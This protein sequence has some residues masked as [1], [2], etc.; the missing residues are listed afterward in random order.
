MEA[1]SALGGVVL[2]AVISMFFTAIF[3]NPLERSI[4]RSWRRFSNSPVALRVSAGRFTNSAIQQL[5]DLDTGKYGVFTLL[6]WSPNRPLIRDPR[7]HRVEYGG[8]PDQ[9]WA[10]TGRLETEQ[11]VQA[12][13][14]RGRTGYAWAVTVDHGE[15]ED[16]DA[17]IVSAAESRYGDLNAIARAMPGVDLVDYVTGRIRDEGI[18]LLRTM[19]PTRLSIQV[20]VVAGSGRVMALRRSAAVQSVPVQWQLGPN[21]TLYPADAPDTPGAIGES[22]FDLAHRC[23]VEE[24]GLYESEVSP[25]RISWFGLAANPDEGVAQN[26]LACTT[27]A[28]SEAQI[29]ERTLNAHSNYESDGFDWIPADS[30]SLLR[31]LKDPERDWIAFSG[32]AAA[33]L[34]RHRLVLERDLDK[35]R[36]RQ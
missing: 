8:A 10:D 29:V 34:A 32:I 14:R 18:D 30:R 33:E 31:A 27:T 7:F 21:E 36:T 6:R 25:I 3:Q 2:G 4:K 13:T 15:H 23:L 26:V 16:A 17:F 9:N 1:I 22:F 5:L 28:L 24:C 19:P 35:V 20:S 12:E 11:M